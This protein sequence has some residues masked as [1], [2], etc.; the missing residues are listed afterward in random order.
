MR[1]R[2]QAGVFLT[3]SF[4]IFTVTVAPVRADLGPPVAVK[5]RPDATQP[6]I[7]GAEYSTVIE[8]TAADDGVIDEFTLEGDGWTITDID[9]QTP[10]TVRAGEVI[11]VRFH[12]RPS[13]AEKPLRLAI[14][15][16]GRQMTRAFRF[17][18]ARFEAGR[19]DGRAVRIDG[20]DPAAAVAAA[21]RLP[22]RHFT[23]HVRPPDGN[24]GPT[25][26]GGTIHLRCVGRIVYQRD[27]GPFVGA[28][29]MTFQVMDDDDIDTEVMA[30]GVTD[31]NGYFDIEFDWD[32]CDITGCDDPD[33]FLRWETENQIVKVARADLLYE[34]YSW[35]TIDTQ[36]YDD[37]TGS[38]INFGEVMPVDLTQHPAMHISNSIVRA[39]R[40]IL[41]VDGTVVEK[42]A[43]VW[44]ESGTT[45]Y[46]SWDEVIHITPNSQWNEITHGHEYG[47]HFMNNYSMA[48]IPNYCVNPVCDTSP[49]NCGHCVW[50]PETDTDAWNEGWP[51]WLG[52]VITRNYP[53]TY[54][55]TPWSAS[56][57]LYSIDTLGS[58]AGQTVNPNTIEGYPA[59]LLF[60]MDDGNVNNDPNGDGVPDWSNEDADGGTPD[61][62]Q[63]VMTG[64]ETN[65]FQVVRIDRPLTPQQFINAYWARFPYEQQDFW[66]TVRNISPNY[67]LPPVPPPILSVPLAQDCQALKEGQSLQLTVNGNGALLKYQWRHN[68]TPLVDGGPVSGATGPTLTINP[69]GPT[70]GGMYDCIVSTCDLSQSTLSPAFRVHVFPAPGTGTQ[71]SGFGRNDFGQL[72]NGELGNPDWPAPRIREV[73]N[74]SN[75]VQVSGGQW[76]SIALKSDGTVWAW[77]RNDMGQLGQGDG[78]I[79]PPEALQVPILT[80][81][82]AISAGGS[83]NMALKADGTV[84]LWGAN[85]NSQLGNAV[86]PDVGAW[87]SP[88]MFPANQLKCVVAIAAGYTTSFALKTDGTVVGWGREL[89]DELGNGPGLTITKNPIP[90]MQLSNVTD[91]VSGNHHVLALRNDGTVW[92]WG[93]NIEGELGDG[94]NDPRDTPVQVPGLTGVTRVRAGVYHSL[95]IAGGGTAWA[96]G[97]N[98]GKLGNG[99]TESSNVPVQPF[100]V[101]PVLDLDGDY[102]TSIFLRANGTVWTCGAN[103]NGALGTAA[104]PPLVLP[105]Q[106][107]AIPFQ[108]TRVFSGYEWNM[109]AH[110]PVFPHI[111]R[112]PVPQ[113]TLN[114]GV[115][116]LTTD[117]FGTAPMQYQWFFNN[118]PMPSGGP[119]QGEATANLNIDP[120]APSHAGNYFLR[121]TNAVGFIDTATVAVSV[122]PSPFCDT[123]EPN[124]SSLWRAESG[125]W[126]TSG[127]AYTCSAPNSYS[128]L[129]F[130]LRNYSA[131]LEISPADIGGAWVRRPPSPAGPGLLL[132]NSGGSLTWYTFNNGNYSLPINPAHNVYTVGAPFTLRIV[133]EGPTSR[134]FVNNG[135]TPV[136]Q[137]TSSGILAPAQFAVLGGSSQSYD[138]ICISPGVSGPPTGNLN[139]DA[140][141][142]GRDI[143][144]FAD[145]ILAG[146]ADPA[147]VAN[148]DFNGNGV[149]DLGDVPGFLAQLIGP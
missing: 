21:L 33:I 1:A 49:T 43:V 119:V 105:Q 75:V 44:P 81:I 70:R 114:G 89:Y 30:S 92:S 123:F 53:T 138:G 84:W 126:T 65:I 109:V 37:F 68:E 25:P 115:L 145:A 96:W 60:D 42:P 48:S 35:S 122:V 17:S 51:N 136:T 111:V 134:A 2:I 19:R 59:A 143:K 148:A 73:V 139:S 80:D 61:C 118:N 120:V 116:R 117:S 24:D 132:Y 103:D 86:P 12:G 100:G 78:A 76:H 8:I 10:R 28:D 108:V 137:I 64:R 40:Y 67:T 99:T 87:G 56:D 11:A 142:N 97:L 77:G 38:F 144:F 66:S 36:I 13:D 71:I 127:S 20:Q 58:C 135:S 34:R 3:A 133:V 79:Y 104:G 146:G 140:A 83:H 110:G 18:A 9:L 130:D 23:D 98:G 94:T 85:D 16:N 50:C 121:L 112:N 93:R 106:V 107:A 102:F 69:V 88:V 39:H 63:D 113:T 74:L 90:V 46:Y 129:P 15:F 5:L 91:I 41:T 131:Q 55:I 72:G 101:S 141:T 128:S 4:M 7:S 54:G 29:A 125:V 57:G 45:S 82:V 124:A 52:S 6:A 27:N 26:H 147:A 22:E 95:A 47:H 14:T 149:V 31:T 62:D 32:D